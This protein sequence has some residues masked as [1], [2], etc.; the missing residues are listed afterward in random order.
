MLFRSRLPRECLSIVRPRSRCPG[1]LRPIP[2][3]ENLPVVSWLLLRGRCAGCGTGISPRYPGV[4]ALTAGLFILAA[5]EL[6]G[7][8]PAVPPHEA[9]VVW[10][11]RAFL[12]SLLVVTTFIDLDHRIIPAAVTRW[13]SA[14]AP[15]AAALFPFLHAP[16]EAPFEALHRASPALAAVAASGLGIL[17][18]WGIIYAVRVLGGILFRKEAMGMGDVWLLGMLGGW[19]GWR[20]AILVLVLAC[21]LG[22]VIG[23]LRWMLTGD[24]TMAFGPYLAV[25][26]GG[27][28]LYRPLLLKAVGLYALWIRGLAGIP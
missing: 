2:W 19:M 27:I 17:T 25:A 3:H 15:A 13:P 11:A 5:Q 1:C 21:F 7:R 6:L 26:A 24:R 10:A 28:L 18:G 22:A 16:V 9:A 12:L 14:L 8:S 4:E 23:G 20:S